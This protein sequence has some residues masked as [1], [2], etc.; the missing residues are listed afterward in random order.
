VATITTIT[1]GWLIQPTKTLLTL[2]KTTAGFFNVTDST[3]Y[4]RY[5]IL[6]G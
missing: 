4:Y 6:I 3:N 2:L 5:A 1:K